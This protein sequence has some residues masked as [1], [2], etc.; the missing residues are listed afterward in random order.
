MP[1]AALS[2]RTLRFAQVCVSPHR[3]VEP[4]QNLRKDRVVALYPV[5][6]VRKRGRTAELAGRDA[7]PDRVE[8]ATDRTPGVP[9]GATDR[10]PVARRDDPHLLWS[11]SGLWRAA[12]EGMVPLLPETAM[13]SMFFPAPCLFQ[14]VR[15]LATSG[16]DRSRPLKAGACRAPAS[17]LAAL[18]GSVTGPAGA[19]QAGKAWCE[20]CAPI[21][22]RRR[23]HGEGRARCLRRHRA[24]GLDICTVERYISP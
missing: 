6:T 17:R 14:A 4:L 16:P 3:A 13:K 1:E 18:T 7:H 22:A 12:R 9:G 19:G 5:E 8:C 23:G 2:T 15:L 24:S 10:L 20:Q 21:P 11:I